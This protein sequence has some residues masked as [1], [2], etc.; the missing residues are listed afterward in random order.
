M[1]Q[2]EQ[3]E[4]IKPFMYCYMGSGMLTNEY[5]ETV[6]IIMAKNTLEA[7]E[8]ANQLQSKWIDVSI[9]PEFG[10]E[11]NV[12]YDLEDGGELV[13]STMD[14]DKITKQW[15]DTRGANNPIHTVKLW[16]KLP[17]KPISTTEA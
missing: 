15:M 8:K 5:D 14:Y 1:K 13:V 10:G 2:E 12:V 4:L 11:Y 6:A 9:E 7:L 17:D 16:K 3:I